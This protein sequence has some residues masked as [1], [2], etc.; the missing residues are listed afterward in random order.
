MPPPAGVCGEEHGRICQEIK[1]VETAIKDHEERLRTGAE[2]FSTLRGDVRV[3]KLLMVLSVIA[4]F[5][6]GATGPK[7]WAYFGH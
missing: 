7:I 1:T 2:M 5:I 3:I 4:S 6:G